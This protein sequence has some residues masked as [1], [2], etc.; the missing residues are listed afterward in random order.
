MLTQSYQKNPHNSHAHS[1]LFQMMKANPYDRS[2]ARS[3]PWPDMAPAQVVTSEKPTVLGAVL[4]L[5]ISTELE[6]QVAP[7]VMKMPCGFVVQNYITTVPETWLQRTLTGAVTKDIPC[8][9]QVYS[10]ACQ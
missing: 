6:P 2:R 1:S 3:W 7:R 8:P 4:T 5:L 9:V 10:P